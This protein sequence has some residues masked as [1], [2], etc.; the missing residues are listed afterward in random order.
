MRAERLVALLFIL[1][2]RS[3][4]TVPELAEAVGVSERTLHRDLAALR[5]AG[6]PIWTETGRHGGVRLVEGWR[7]RLDGLTSREAVALFAMGAP[8]A[9]AEL[10][11]GTA[12]SAAHAKVAATL[13]PALRDQAQLVAQRFHLD[14]PDWFRSE[15]DTAQLAT[16][17]RAVWNS[18][19][20][21]LGYRRDRT[22]VERTVDPLGLVL[23]AGIWY[24]VAGVDG[25]VRTY[26]V[27]RIV[28][29][30]ELDEAFERP[31]DFDLA[32]WWEQSSVQF[33]RSLQ[34][35]DVRIRL[36]TRGYRTLPR[37]FD[38]DVARAALATAGPPDA[39]GRREL[40][41]GLESPEIAAGQLLALG[42]EVE[43]LEPPAARA[44]F[45][46]AARRMAQT[47][48]LERAPAPPA[49]ERQPAE[50]SPAEPSPAQR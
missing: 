27:G 6:V 43:I 2:R 40:T 31:E 24:L 22:T 4:A 14:A 10:G 48:A 7:S 41:I 36:S 46:E 28:A 13:P 18:H 44:A 11:L 19:R 5:E 20:T 49:A 17:A 21:R 32:D 23:K 35:V 3:A 12:V 29:A 9:L 26:R 30:E 34:R 50:P 8:R 39:E 33:E 25:T 47:H 37:M 1:Q 15:E 45:A 38:A 42:V 16:V